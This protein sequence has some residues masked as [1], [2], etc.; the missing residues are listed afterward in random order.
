MGEGSNSL[1]DS[2]RTKLASRRSHSTPPDIEAQS[3]LYYSK[4][5]PLPSHPAP[6]VNMYQ[7][8]NRTPQTTA[9][10]MSLNDPYMRYDPRAYQ[11]AAIKHQQVSSIP[12]GH[13]PPALK[14]TT[15][16]LQLPRPR[17]TWRRS[18]DLSEEKT[19][20]RTVSWHEGDQ[21]DKVDLA[22]ALPPEFLD[23]PPK[24]SSIEKT[25][26]DRPDLW[27]GYGHGHSLDV[28]G[29]TKYE[30][31]LPRIVTPESPD[32]LPR[33]CSDYSSSSN[34]PSPSQALTVDGLLQHPMLR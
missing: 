31:H 29:S 8:P 12:R 3:R 10:T 2:L 11:S 32:E 9:N 5:D 16:L 4:S 27:T 24:Y 18:L 26:N 33:S 7:V 20:R 22:Y 30:K 19:E 21:R 25:S 28:S 1:I 6:I 15:P 17:A 13:M 34:K 14:P 23:L